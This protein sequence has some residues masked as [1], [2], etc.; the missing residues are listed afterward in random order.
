MNTIQGCNF[1]ISDKNC[2]KEIKAYKNEVWYFYG[3]SAFTI[4]LGDCDNFPF[5]VV[6]LGKL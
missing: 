2:K 6:K 4:L 3:W 5:E 1:P